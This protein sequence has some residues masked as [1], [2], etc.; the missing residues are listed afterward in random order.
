MTA[1]KEASP[2]AVEV[3]ND[4]E[5]QSVII[6]LSYT[7]AH[8]PARNL[9]ARIAP[10]LGSN[11]YSFKVGEHELLHAEPEKLRERA[12]TGNFVLWPFPNRVRH[13]HYTYQG[14]EY[15]LS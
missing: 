2:Y 7:D 1:S 8:N 3:I 10:D 12:H 11:F 6:A 5:L 14:H 15:S 4:D 9:H 13:K